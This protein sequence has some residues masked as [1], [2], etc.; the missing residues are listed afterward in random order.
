M[1]RKI[2]IYIPTK[3]YILITNMEKN[4]IYVNLVLARIK[5]DMVTYVDVC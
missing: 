5:I 2:D 4:I 1:T 3:C